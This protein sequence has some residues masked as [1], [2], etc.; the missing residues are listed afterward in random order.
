MSNIR[1][2]QKFRDCYAEEFDFIKKSDTSEEYAFCCACVCDISI[3]YGGRNDI[4]VHGRREKHKTVYASMKNSSKISD[5][6]SSSS[7]L[8]AIRAEVLFT[9]FLIEHNIA[10]A[11]FNFTA[12]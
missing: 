1:R 6:M 8:Q 9:N 5:F 10:L 3:A 11:C 12:Q 4:V 7:D 2:T